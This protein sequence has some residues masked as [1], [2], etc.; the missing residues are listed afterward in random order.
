MKK[1]DV[2]IPGD[3]T[4]WGTI[5]T[6][7]PADS[8]FV[9]NNE[10]TGDSKNFDST[11][12][13]ILTK[14]KDSVQYNPTD[15][16]YPPKDQYEAIFTDGV[17]HLLVVAN[18]TLKY[19]SGGGTFSDVTSG[20][21]SNGNFE[22][23]IYD[24][25]VYMSNGINS[26]QAYDRTVS[27]GGVTYT[28][29]KTKDM[30][31]QVPGT[32]PTVGVHTAGGS[33]PAGGHTYKV[34]YLYYD[35]EE[36]NGG[37][38][39]T[40]TTVSNPNNTVPLT[41]V[42]VGG[43]GV[44][45]RK[46]YRDDNDGVYRLVGTI[47]D[48]TTA[49]FSDTASVGTALIPIDN[50]VPPSFKY[51]IT[52]LDRNWIAGIPGEPS[53]LR[54]SDAGLPSIFPASNSLLCNP[55]DPITALVVFNDRIIVFNRN[56]MGQIIGTTTDT[57]RYSEIPSSIGCVD[58]RSIQIR[59]NVGVPVLLWLSDK[60]FYSYNGS[61]V[62]YISDPLEN[63]VNLNIQQS[64]QV[65]GLNAQT[66]ESQFNAGT[67]S[68]AILTTGGLITVANPKRIWDDETDWDAGSSLT[69]IT[70]HDGSNSIECVTNY[71]PSYSTGSHANTQQSGNDVV[72]PV[73]TDFTGESHLT[74]TDNFFV[75]ANGYFAQSVI[76]SR[77]GTM[78]NV[79]FVINN[80]GIVN[81]TLIV[82]VR[83]DL[84]GLPFATLFST[85]SV[86]PA[87]T[88]GTFTFP[89][90]IP[91]TGGTR[92]WL[93]AGTTDVGLGFFLRSYNGFKFNNGDV[94]VVQA[95]GNDTTWTTVT[96]GN[97]SIATAYACVT[98]SVA[99][100]GI[101]TSQTY[102]SSSDNAV[103]A[104]I[105]H[106][107]LFPTSTSSIT[108]IDASNDSTLS[109]GVITQ[110]FNNLNGSSAISLSGKRYWRI[111][112]RLI[113]TDDRVTPTVGQPNLTFATTSEWISDV[114]DHTT[115]VTALNSLVTTSTIPIGTSVTTEI[116]TSADNITYSAYSALGSASVQ[117]YSKI[118][119][120]ITSTTDNVTSANVQS[121]LFT[122]TV[123]SNIISS[124][125]DTGN[126]PAG[127]DIFQTA[128]SINGGNIVM[129]MRTASTVLGLTSAT[130]YTVTNGSFP[131]I[132]VNRYAN[133]RMTLTAH[134]DQVPTIDS[135]TVGWFISTVNSIRVASLFYNR[136]YY[137]AAA[138]YNQAAN[139]LLLVFDGEGM[140]RI[141]KE[142]SINTLSF[143][144]NDPYYGSSTTGL[145]YK[146]LYGNTSAIE[147]IVDTKEL[148]LDY[149]DKTKVCRNVRINGNST[150][151]VLYVQFSAD[152]G[153]TWINMIDP[154][155][156]L[157]Y[158]VTPND[159][160]KFSVKFVPAFIEGQVTA[161]RTI[162]F[163]VKESTAA[164]V[165]LESLKAELWIRAGERNG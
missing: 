77:T 148:D 136:T 11:V 25:R 66:T 128:S 28:V 88:S 10:L 95:V 5:K 127:W 90:S 19:T 150:G 56:S 155:T 138:E 2:K 104:N 121:V 110:T 117:R 125:I 97:R 119:I 126:T 48:N 120:T 85:T 115:D 122:W 23:T 76:P 29:P 160:S 80:N 109:S 68:P 102:D 135:V 36:S 131:S 26:P 106:T 22:F 81:K 96:S 108:T 47:A 45:A 92:Y 94:N 112:I 161:G 149:P 17:R 61:S 162:K 151:A 46:I 14:R 118:R 33:V 38:A 163:R 74:S 134:A 79:S 39:T 139:N 93:E 35:V 67:K 87:S 57:F 32:A 144:F 116:A 65:K 130:W 6:K 13:G 157:S 9:G 113:T 62:N 124:N 165:E 64:Q 3:N 132:P 129:E 141:Y 52:H 7:Y 78:T 123:V 49:T 153:F 43:Y 145:I 154:Y 152:G 82:K 158:V 27:Y 34:T 70:T 58:N 114:V 143:F 42:P 20:Y 105:S 54:F 71:N 53:I 101:W 30:G 159:G 41:S 8:V 75:L 137:L 18:G 147:M 86:I 89:V 91:V 37:V 31:A 69:N 12:K 83:G 156:G 146:F 4:E 55:K 140:W 51:V 133:W 1:V 21:S 107:G 164:E 15:F 142:L 24:D 84:A 59:V 103:A 111:T 50:D 98:T 60:G 16:T 63:L 44:T 100:S 40:V 99:S 72:L 73:T